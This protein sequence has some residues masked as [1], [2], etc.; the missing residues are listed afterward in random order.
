MEIDFHYY[1]TYLAAGLAGYD[2]TAPDE[3]TLSDAA[4]I[5]YAAQYV[6]DLDESRVLENDAFI[7]QSRDFTPVA[8]V[9]TSKQIAALEVGIGEWAPEKLQKLRQV[10][11]AFHF[12]PGNYG[13]NPER[14][15][16]WQSGGVCA[17]IKKT[18]PRLGPSFN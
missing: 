14:L 1:A 9:Q 3:V 7:I 8:T 13:D 6:D 17:A 5:A 11:S 15:P 2:T 12:L 10:W 16:L 4:K 18:T